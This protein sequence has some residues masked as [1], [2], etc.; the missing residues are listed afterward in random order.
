MDLSVRMQGVH[1]DQS[2]RLS[3]SLLFLSS[4]THSEVLSKEKV[5]PKKNLAKHTN[6][7]KFTLS[8]CYSL[9]YSLMSCLAIVLAV[10]A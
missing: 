4:L 10:I 9:E 7:V 3:G 8:Q 6:E 5:D 2:S 1:C